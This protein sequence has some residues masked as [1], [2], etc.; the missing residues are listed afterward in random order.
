[1]GTPTQ[2]DVSASIKRVGDNAVRRGRR[3]NVNYE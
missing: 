2:V 1:M 3:G